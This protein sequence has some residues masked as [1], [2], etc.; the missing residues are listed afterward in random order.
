MKARDIKKALE[1]K[2]FTKKE[3]K[4]HTKYTL[5]RNGK[6]TRVSVVF[7]RGRSKQELG[8]ELI[9]RIMKQLHFDNDKNKFKDFVDCPMGKNDYIHYLISKG[10]LE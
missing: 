10:V 7:S 4:R 8:E 3:G 9:R 1:K 2:G 5:Y 6:K